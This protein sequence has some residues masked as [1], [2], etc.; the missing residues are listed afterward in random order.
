MFGAGLKSV[1]WVSK[2]ILTKSREEEI[3][4]CFDYPTREFQYPD[5]LDDFEM[6]L[7]T[8]RRDSTDDVDEQN[9]NDNCNIFEKKIFDRLIVIDN[10]LG[11]TD[12]S[13]DF[14]IF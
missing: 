6:L 11:L 4:T 5:D 8:F 10:V 12:K 2:I 7:Q 13:N 3:R 1:D 14:S 9:T